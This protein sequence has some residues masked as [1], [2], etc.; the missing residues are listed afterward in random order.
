M[1]VA[2]QGVSIESTAKNEPSYAVDLGD[3]E[4]L[5]QVGQLGRPGA[6]QGSERAGAVVSDLIDVMPKTK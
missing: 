6:D 2:V 5:E 4:P 3:R 1:F